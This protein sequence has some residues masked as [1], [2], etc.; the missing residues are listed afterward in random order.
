MLLAVV[1]SGFVVRVLP[2]TLPIPLVQ[3]AFGALLAGV[4]RS[5]F[6]LDPALFFLLFVPP[7]LFLDGWRI[8][9]YGLLRDKATILELALGLVAFT[10]LGIGFLIHAMI[11]AMPLP[12][13]FALAAIVSPT[14]P[15]AVTSIASRTPVPRRLLH[16]LQGEALLNDASGLVLFAFAVGVAMTGVFSP[17]SAAAAF[18]WAIAGG[19]GA[20]F[21]LTRAATS[22]QM[23]LSGRFGEEAGSPILVSLLLPFGAYL[24]ADALGASGIL[25]AVSA[26]ITMSYVELTGRAPATTRVDRTAVWNSLQ[27]ALNGLVFVLLGEQLPG[28][29]AGAVVSVREGGHANPGWLAAYALAISLGLALLRFAWVWTSL[30]LTMFAARQRGERVAKPPWRIVAVLS[31]AGV[32][33]AITLAG[34]MTLPMLLPDGSP[35]PARD[36]AVFLA[37]SVILL[38]LLAASVG[39]P[40]LL[41]GLEMPSEKG[42]HRAEEDARNGAALAAIAAVEA[43]LQAVPREADDAEAYAI[44]AASLIERYRRRVELHGPASNQKVTHRRRVDQAERALLMAGLHAEREA[45]FELA[46]QSRIS[47]EASR[48]LVREIDLLEARY[49]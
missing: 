20:G 10:V 38:S 19:V 7:L 48:K 30:R 41:K 40:A 11:P 42:T 2:F 37:A 15:V 9:N 32:R 13:A 24:L 8:P 43:A 16:I 14:D 4:F 29:L 17:A 5:G 47:D 3:I 45:V 27:F 21:A 22:L 25:A 49:R 26:G 39:M 28:L 46:R 33:G 36:L 35:F 18:L 44:A 12:V 6:T 34:V 1:A 31:L 23:A